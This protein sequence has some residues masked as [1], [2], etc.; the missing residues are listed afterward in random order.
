MKRVALLLTLLL[1]AAGAFAQPAP[2]AKALPAKAPTIKVVPP[3]KAVVVPAKAPTATP[4]TKP[5]I[6]AKAPAAQPA[7][8]PASQKV[9]V[10]KDTAGAISTG[11]R[12]LYELQHKNWRHA[13]ALLLMLLIFV[14]RR[15]GEKFL[16]LRKVP[17]RYLG[18]VTA[19]VAVLYA[20]GLALGTKGAFDWSAF[21][22]NAIITCGESF[23]YWEVGG[24]FA[25]EKLLG[26]T[27]AK[28]RRKAAAKP[29]EKPAAE[30]APPTE[31][32]AD[33]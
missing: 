12:V 31:I 6:T 15:Y 7:S 20:L 19:G 5:A 2:A 23:L 27:P 8:V 26:E 28:K 3:A 24:K 16:A 17:D 9:E 25:L 13:A 29:A 22:A 32:K 18:F 30:I 10:P 11:Q 33:K 14:W 4:A 21:A 1:V